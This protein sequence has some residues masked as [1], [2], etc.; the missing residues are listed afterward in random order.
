MD[1]SS[2][3]NTVFQLCDGSDSEG[4][5]E[6]ASTISP[7]LSHMEAPKLQ[8]FS[9]MAESIK[10]QEGFLTSIYE[11]VSGCFLA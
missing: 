11:G 1:T 9:R 4:V 2:G 5:V 6:D 10:M 8:N 3:I 7:T